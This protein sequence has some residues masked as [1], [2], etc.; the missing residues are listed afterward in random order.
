MTPMSLP[1]SV[2][3]LPTGFANRWQVA[4]VL[5]GVMLTL[6]WAMF[7]IGFPLYLLNII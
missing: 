4:A 3:D 7:L 6:V 5:F 1:M 2:K